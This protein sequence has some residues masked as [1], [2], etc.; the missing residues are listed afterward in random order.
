MSQT[1]T[2][3]ESS[4]CN[5]VTTLL[6]P[7]MNSCLYFR[8]SSFRLPY[9]VGVRAPIQ[10]IRIYTYIHNWDDVDRCKLFALL[11]I[12]LICEQLLF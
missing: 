11:C 7:L 2:T 10:N 6:W 12:V 1:M 3:T 8:I 4:N 9:N 5:S